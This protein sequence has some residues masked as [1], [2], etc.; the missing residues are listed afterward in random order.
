MVR[1]KAELEVSVR[2]IR[3]TV[4]VDIEEWKMAIPYCFH[5]ELNVLI[6]TVQ[7]VKRL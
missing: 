6:D 1:I 4:R 5:S 3:F 7:V 2:A